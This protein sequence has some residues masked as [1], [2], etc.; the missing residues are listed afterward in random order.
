MADTTTD[1]FLDAPESATPAYAEPPLP[2]RSPRRRLATWM[3]TGGWLV[4][5]VVIGAVVV[6]MLHSGTSANANR[7]PAGAPVANQGP[8]NAAGGGPAGGFAGGPDQGGPGGGL[9]GEQH[10][11]GKLTAVGAASVTVQGTT[12]AATY[13]VDASTVVVKDGQRVSSLSALT[14]GDTV[15]VHVYPQNGATHTEL[16]IDTG[17]TS[18]T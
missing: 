15:V 11:V 4:A 18:Q 1:D 9:P 12:G 16:I 2:A 8:A 5:G 6:A 17:G 14:I 7:L 13:P 10:V 3:S